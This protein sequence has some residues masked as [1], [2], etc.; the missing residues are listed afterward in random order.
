MI[1]CL[2]ARYRFRM[3]TVECNGNFAYREAMSTKIFFI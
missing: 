2:N 1:M 3:V